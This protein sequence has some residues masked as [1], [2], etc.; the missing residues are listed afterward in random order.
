MFCWD[1]CYTTI[2]IQGLSQCLGRVI[3]EKVM[4]SFKLILL[5]VFCPEVCPFRAVS[6]NMIWVGAGIVELSVSIN[7]SFVGFRL[8]HPWVMSTF[9]LL[10]WRLWVP[11]TLNARYSTSDFH[12]QCTGSLSVVTNSLL[13]G[14]LLWKSI[15]TCY[16]HSA[17]L[18]QYKSSQMYPITN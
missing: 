16:M 7:P 13:G 5:C 14:K 11:G 12:P 3:W 1:L 4:Q 17:L 2:P 9:H 10:L 6:T 8:K 18:F 15:S